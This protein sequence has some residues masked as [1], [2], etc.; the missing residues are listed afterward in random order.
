MISNLDMTFK[1]NLPIET[2]LFG[3]FNGLSNED[4]CLTMKLYIPKVVC[5][6]DNQV[7]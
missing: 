1:I 2:D 7:S 3:S 6:V 5:Y 4:H